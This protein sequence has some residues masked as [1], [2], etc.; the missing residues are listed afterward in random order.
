V[1]GFLMS[2]SEQDLSLKKLPKQEIKQAKAEIAQPIQMTP[3]SIDLAAKQA[4]REL[5]RAE[6]ELLKHFEQL[7]KELAKSRRDPT[8]PM[9]MTPESIDLAGKQAIE[10]W[11]R[12]QEQAGGSKFNIG[13]SG[14]GLERSISDSAEYW[15]KRPQSET[16]LQSGKWSQRLEP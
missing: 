12:S 1:K 5:D 8:Q 6:K 14:R 4:L 16:A 7:E 10:Q 9:Q 3:E 15:A 2:D 13:S 11:E